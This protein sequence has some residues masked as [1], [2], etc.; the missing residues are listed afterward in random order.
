MPD[1]AHQQARQTFHCPGGREFDNILHCGAQ[2]NHA[3]LPASEQ[4]S[5]VNKQNVAEHT[6]EDRKRKP[7]RL[8]YKATKCS[9]GLLDNL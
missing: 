2:E 3:R 9:V 4:T 1:R 5:R 8:G 6:E 7:D